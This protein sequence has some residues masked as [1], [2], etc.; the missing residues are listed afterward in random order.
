MANWLRNTVLAYIL[1]G[2]APY[3][4]LE[5]IVVLVSYAR[6]T[7]TFIAGLRCRKNDTAPAPEL[8]VF[9]SVAPAA[10][11]FH[12]YFNCLGKG[13][14]KGGGVKNPLELDILQ[15]LYHLCKGNYMFSHTFC[16][17]ICRLHANT[18]E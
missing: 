17:L 7:K 1:W 14:H 12:T 4:K 5:V 16:L 2:I 11:R 13:V 3:L 9:M 6:T 8:L 18:T 10:V 15:K